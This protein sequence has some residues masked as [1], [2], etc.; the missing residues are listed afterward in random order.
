[1][2]TLTRNLREQEKLQKMQSVVMNLRQL[3]DRREATEAEKYEE[4]K[5]LEGMQKKL[6]SIQRK[7]AITACVGVLLAVGLNEVCAAPLYSTALSEADAERKCNSS[8]EWPLKVGQTA[9]SLL[10]IGQ[11]VSEKPIARMPMRSDSPTIVAFEGVNLRCLEQVFHYIEKKRLLDAS[12]FAN[13]KKHVSSHRMN[14]NAFKQG[15]SKKM[16]LKLLFEMFIC[17][18]HAVCLPIPSLEPSALQHC[19]S[20]VNICP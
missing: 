14:G 3:K 13:V 20:S 9:F 12:S 2:N 19:H 16:L 11:L 10:L 18:V 5:L 8:L 17:G 4:H 1:M 7:M 15:A 6:H